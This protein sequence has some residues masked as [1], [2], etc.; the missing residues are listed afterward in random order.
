MDPRIKRNKTSSP[1]DNSPKE[2]KKK[3]TVE[4]NVSY[5]GKGCHRLVS[6]ALLV[7]FF[8]T[9]IAGCSKFVHL[10]SEQKD[11]GSRLDSD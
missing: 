5:C 3:L 2:E 11:A 4:E 7:F 9:S 10:V 1:V 8:T 6:I